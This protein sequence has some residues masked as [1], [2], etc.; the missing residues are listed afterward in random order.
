MA[1]GYDNV[2]NQVSRSDTIGGAAAGTVNRVYDTLNRVTRITQSGSGVAEKRVDL[3]YDAAS[4]WA[5]ISRYAD[6]AG[7][8]H[9]ASS[10]YTYDAASRL[11]RLAHSPSTTP[12]APGVVDGLF[13]YY[14][15]AYDAADRITQV[16]S[17][18]GVSTYN[19][20]VIDQLLGADYSF[21]GDESYT[22]DANGN[23]T[24]TGYTTG[25]NNRLLS[26]G[27]YNYEYD[28]EGNRTRR[29]NIATGEVTE[30]SWD[31]RNR[32]VHV[33]VKSSGGIVL[34]DFYYTY[35]VNDRRIAKSVDTD[36]AGP[37]AAE[38]E[39]FVDDG[40]HIALT[41]DGAG[42]VTH[43]YLYGPNVDQILADENAAGEILWPLAD[44]QG[45]VRDLVSSDGTLRDHITYDAF[46]RVAAETGP[47]ANDRFA[48]TGRE[49]DPETGL[50]YY[51]ARY[52]DA[53][54]GRFLAEDPL[55]FQGGD[56]NLFSYVRNTSTNAVDPLG[57]ALRAPLP[58]PLANPNLAGAMQVG[59]GL[60]QGATAMAL[61]GLPGGA[62][63]AVPLALRAGDNI[64]TGIGTIRDQQLHNTLLNTGLRNL[65]TGL[66]LSP[67]AAAIL[68][69]LSEAGF[70]ITLG[71][72]SARLLT[73]AQVEALI[74][75]TLGRTPSGE[76]TICLTQRYTL[77]R[78]A[79]G[80]RVA[81]A[82]DDVTPLEGPLSAGQAKLLSRLRDAAGR[83][84]LRTGEIT[85]TDIAALTGHT[86]AEF[87]VIRTTDG[88][89]QLI[90]L[91]RMGGALP[92]DT[93]RL[94]IHSHPGGTDAIRLGVSGD[95]VNA[96][97]VLARARGATTPQWS[98]IV[99]SDGTVAKFGA[100]GEPILL[101][102]YLFGGWRYPRRP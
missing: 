62:F 12:P 19:Y 33:T 101:K 81:S 41:L 96:L 9:V 59:L 39:R 36:G 72:T 55:G 16:S 90:Q 27:T 75:E 20:D 13:A 86:R 58:N 53:A 45:T 44:H 87:A 3:S 79:R 95:D 4:Q 10:H 26:D 28:A 56:T 7:A 29:V 73:R 42:Q 102:Q 11:T 91:G 74:L 66:N 49:L 68:A 50:Y 31:Y 32:L 76:T 51:R 54:S 61:I 94:I 82:F 84:T 48:Y 14:D 5:R 2:G 70:D 88:Q 57:L 85:T 8:Q 40:N 67:E 37:A 69:A 83:L 30:Y 100:S 24:N 77:G 99:N 63:L 6:L 46:G 98:L 93:A 25:A 18:D 80:L 34:G 38:V 97:S 64:G 71:N 43:R 60:T 78:F 65:G 47:S 23:R 21:Q 1:Y 35:D 22:Y 92:E 17:K 15:Y 89:R 52:Y